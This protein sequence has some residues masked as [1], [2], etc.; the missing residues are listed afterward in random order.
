M[1]FENAEI[2]VIKSNR[3]T[4]SIQINPAKVTVRVPLKMNQNEIDC[5]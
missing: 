3:K 5:D 2:L 4:I 1:I